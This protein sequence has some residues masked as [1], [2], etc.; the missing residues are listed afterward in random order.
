[1]GC[2]CGNEAQIDC[3]QMDGKKICDPK[4]DQFAIC[5]AAGN[6]CGDNLKDSCDGDHIVYCV[7]GYKTK[8]DCKTLGFK[9]CGALEVNGNRLGST[10]K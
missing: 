8:T 4:S 6:E 7:D 5:V 2:Y 10:C 1:M 3:T 9:T